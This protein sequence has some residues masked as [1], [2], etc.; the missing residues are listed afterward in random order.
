MFALSGKPHHSIG[1]WR[2]RVGERR[3]RYLLESD[4]SG[5]VGDITRENHAERIVLCI[6]ACNGLSNEALKGTS[7]HELVKAMFQI[8]PFARAKAE[9]LGVESAEG[10]SAWLSVDRVIGLLAMVFDR[11]P[12][13]IYHLSLQ[14]AQQ[15]TDY[16]RQNF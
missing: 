14:S 9:Q 16:F 3:E 10:K 8:V 5:H 13:D 4:V 12:A 1:T 6:N 7:A 2:V 11:T 15:R